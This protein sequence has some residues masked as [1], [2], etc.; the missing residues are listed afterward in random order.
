MRAKRE[1]AK[2]KN[3]NDLS[4]K[5]KE[6]IPLTHENNEHQSRH[7][8]HIDVLAQGNDDWFWVRL[9]SLYLQ[10][11]HVL[12]V[13]RLQRF[14]CVG[15]GRQLEAVFSVVVWECR[16]VAFPDDYGGSGDRMASI[17]SDVSWKSSKI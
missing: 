4:C 2:Q 14:D 16:E 1:I 11:F 12:E 5:K 3:N 15:A 7:A 13:A 9:N 17:V 8:I 6:Q 10:Y